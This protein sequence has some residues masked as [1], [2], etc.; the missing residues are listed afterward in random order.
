MLTPAWLAAARK[1][2]GLTEIVGSRHEPRVVEFFAEAGHP[3]VKDDE[4]AWC[5]AFVGAKLAEAGVKSTGL[6]NA[7]SYLGWGV[8]LKAPVPGAIV[9]FKRGSSTWQGHV[10]F[11]VGDA[12]ASIRVLGGNQAN[13]VS[14]ALYGKASLLGYRWP[15]EVPLPSEALQPATFLLN[16]PTLQIGAHSDAVGA[17]QR[18]LNAL[19]AAT[20]PLLADGRFGPKTRDATVAF[21]RRRMLALDG[22]VH[23]ADWVALDTALE[24][25]G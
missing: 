16:R 22:V 20:P 5:A 4:T 25:L 7:R 14:E 18:G 9:V 8:A 6:L 19:R 23:A 12:G 11:C 24:A 2:I 1:D 10:A 15:D 17:W 21:Q 13:A 3:Y